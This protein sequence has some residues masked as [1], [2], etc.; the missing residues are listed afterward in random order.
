[1]NRF[2]VVS[3]NKKIIV[4]DSFSSEPREFY[5]VDERIPKRFAEFSVCETICFSPLKNVFALVTD[6]NMVK[7][8][9]AN[10]KKEIWVMKEH[11]QRVWSVNFS[12]DGSKVV[13]GSRDTFVIIT[14]STNGSVL[15]K[16]RCHQE[17]FCVHFCDKNHVVCSLIDGALQMWNID[18]KKC[19]R[20][21]LEPF[22]DLSFCS[23]AVSPNKLFMAWGGTEGVMKVWNLVTKECIWTWNAHKGHVRCMN[24]SNSGK[25]LISGA[26]S[27]TAVLWDV[28]T[29]SI[30]RKFQE[31]G[32][33]YRCFISSDESLVFTSHD[34]TVNIWDT[35][36][37]SR[38]QKI[39]LSASVYSMSI[40]SDGSKMAVGC[41]DCILSFFQRLPGA[42]SCT[43]KSPFSAALC[44]DQSLVVIVN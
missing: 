2:E 38:L 40:S 14:D 1:M 11:T 39:F 13:S 15:T 37:G 10:T 16:F 24:F 22:C 19:V 36:S 28:E 35:R 44:L 33:V 3:F 4:C 43:F 32:L 8:L 41:G 18:S 23:C 5:K 31:N 29:K 7:M 27:N 17:V 26:D 21:F 20:I 34:R 25:K 12:V 6:F 30:I 42:V 9:C